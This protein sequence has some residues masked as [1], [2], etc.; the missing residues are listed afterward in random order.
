MLIS[1]SHV[2]TS[3]LVSVHRGRRR[4]ASFCYAECSS[5][6]RASG[7]S[8][9]LVLKLPLAGDVVNKIVLSEGSCLHVDSAGQ[10]RAD[11]KSP[12]DGGSRR[13]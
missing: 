7:S 4:R 6:R 2:L 8:M 12:R 11:A 3:Y 1:I 9:R 10:W 5:L 13:Q